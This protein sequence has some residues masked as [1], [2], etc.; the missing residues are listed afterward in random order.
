MA[1]YAAQAGLKAIV[2]IPKDNI[3]Y[4]K[5]SQAMAYGSK[6]VQV[7]GNFDK[8]MDLV[9]K[10]S[11]EMELYLL[12]SINPWRVE[13]QKSIIYE[14]IQQRGWTIPEW[15]V[16]PAGNLGNLSAFGKALR[17]LVELGWIEKAPRLVAIQAELA[18]P[19]YRLWAKKERKI[20]PIEPTTIASAIKIGNPVSWEKGIRAIEETNGVVEVVSDDEIVDAKAQ[21]DRSGIGC[22]PASAAS[23]A[24]AKKLREKGVIKLDDDVVCILTGNLLKD[25]EATLNLYQGKLREVEPKLKNE[26]YDLDDNSVGSLRRIIDS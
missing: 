10:A 11:K 18:D 8:A 1:S 16:L 25:P 24:G 13:G 3:A 12:N 20:T 17:E 6:I 2:F 15:I 21:V 5:L 19:F 23:I 22:E 7:E 9:Q 26:L 4:G 14:L